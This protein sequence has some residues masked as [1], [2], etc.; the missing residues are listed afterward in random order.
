MQPLRAFRKKVYSL[1]PLVCALRQHHH[2][3]RGQDLASLVGRQVD[4]GDGS[5][6]PT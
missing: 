3:V 6:D 2:R 1:P 4:R 5:G